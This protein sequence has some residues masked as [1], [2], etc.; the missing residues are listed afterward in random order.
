MLSIYALAKKIVFAN[1]LS[2]QSNYMGRIH[3]GLS[4]TINFHILDVVYVKY[5]TLSTHEQL[6]HHLKSHAFIHAP[7]KDP[8]SN[9]MQL[10]N[11]PCTAQVAGHTLH[12][13]D[14][15]TDA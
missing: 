1:I 12:K 11:P 6:V 2:T 13:S 14:P 3:L 8:C 15:T 10:Q 9:T 5:G 4:V 7:P